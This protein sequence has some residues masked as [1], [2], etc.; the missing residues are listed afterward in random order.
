[1]P[2][3]QT[4]TKPSINNINEGSCIDNILIK[5]SSIDAI[6]FKL[7]NLFTDHYPLFLSIN[8]IKQNVNNNTFISIN[9]NK[10][11]KIANE[12]NWSSILSMR[13]PNN[14]TNELISLI[15]KCSDL[16]G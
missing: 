7:Q 6:P 8:K 16:I 2:G 4:I 3:F 9:Y 15:K 13:D 5:T 11:K 14:A 10:L 1:M 12:I